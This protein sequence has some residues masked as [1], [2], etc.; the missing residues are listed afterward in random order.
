MPHIIFAALICSHVATALFASP[1]NAIMQMVSHGLSGLVGVVFSLIQ[2][3]T[4]MHFTH[5]PW[6]RPAFL[7]K[8]VKSKMAYPST[9]ATISMMVMGTIL[10]VCIGLAVNS[11]KPVAKDRTKTNTTED[12]DNDE[13]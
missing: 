3:K 9:V 6:Y 4:Y 13:S 11:L 2:G 1:T 5:V 10:S 12:S 8:V 7:E